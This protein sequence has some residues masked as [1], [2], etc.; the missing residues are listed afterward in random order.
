VGKWLDYNINLVNIMDMSKAR[1]IDYIYSAHRFLS[2]LESEPRDYGSGDMLYATEIHTVV[3]VEK[4]SGCNLTTL[5]CILHVSPAAASKF[6]AKL[7]R[8]G[9]ITKYK[10]AN[11][12][13]DVLFEVTEKGKQAARGHD[14]FERRTFGPLLRVEKDLGPEERGVIEAFFQ[15]LL[16]NAK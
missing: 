7:I 2:E 14:Q 16:V 9:Y 12:L 11:N 3:E 8:R 1:L 13:R 6:V 10:A 4:N 5:A 15:K